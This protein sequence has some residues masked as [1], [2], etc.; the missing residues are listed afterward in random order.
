M[1]GHAVLLILTTICNMQIYNYLSNLPTQAT[2]AGK[3]DYLLDTLT[4]F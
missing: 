2:N 1:N 4:M 3:Q